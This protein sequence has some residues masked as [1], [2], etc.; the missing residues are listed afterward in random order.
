MEIT[1]DDAP[2]RRDGEGISDYFSRSQDYWVQKA[3]EIYEEE[4]ETI[5]DRKLVRFAKEICE[6][7]CDR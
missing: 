3:R 5:S 4:G 1:F 6:E 7:A 2:D